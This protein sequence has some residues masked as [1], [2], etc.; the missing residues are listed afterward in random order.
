MVKICLKFG[1]YFTFLGLDEDGDYTVFEDVGFL[2]EVGQYISS[3]RL[4]DQLTLATRNSKDVKDQGVQLAEFNYAGELNLLL[5][6][7][8]NNNL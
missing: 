6:Y 4:N 3:N 2:K 5:I 1:K 8:K 7:L